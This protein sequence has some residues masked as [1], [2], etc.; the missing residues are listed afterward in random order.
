MQL[1]S[2]ITDSECHDILQRHADGLVEASE[3]RRL[4]AESLHRSA[5]VAAVAKKGRAVRTPDGSG[6][7]G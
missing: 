6:P 1:T 4:I 7:G 2:L 5:I 3:A